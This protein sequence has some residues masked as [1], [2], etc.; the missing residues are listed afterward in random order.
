MSEMGRIIQWNQIAGNPTTL[1]SIEELQGTPI[2]LVK[3]E[4]NELLDAI[5]KADYIEL[6]DAAGDILVVCNGL[7]NQMDTP[8]KSDSELSSVPLLS[9]NEAFDL[10]LRLRNT[11]KDVSELDTNE[12]I[13][14]V[15]YSA[16]KVAL[17]FCYVCKVSPME[18]LRRINDSNFSKFCTDPQ[19]SKW[20]VDSY[21]LS[22]RYHHVHY[23]QIGDYYIIR[24]YNGLNERPKV[25]KGLGYAEPELFDLAIEAKNNFCFSILN[26]GGD[27][28]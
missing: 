15:A 22:T 14:R 6:L 2:G 11:L 28:V 25:L 20:S 12:K 10:L 18:I 24:G 13:I 5:V 23:V 8:I 9:A 19:E 17:S 21:E 27:N 16:I 7:L 1:L 3:E 4:I 26:N